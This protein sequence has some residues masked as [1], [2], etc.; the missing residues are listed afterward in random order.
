MR[1]AVVGAGVVGGY[2]GGR[3][4][5]AGEGVTF[6]ARGATLHAFR[7]SGLQVDAPRTAIRILASLEGLTCPEE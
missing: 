6:I 3:L 2:F 4:S 5:H 7:E 1:I